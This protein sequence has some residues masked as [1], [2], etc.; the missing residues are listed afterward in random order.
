MLALMKAKGKYI[1]SM[2]LGFSLRTEIVYLFGLGLVS[3]ITDHFQSKR[4]AGTEIRNTDA[5]T[6]S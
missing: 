2:H 4:R 6:Q 3:G 1:Y 5:N